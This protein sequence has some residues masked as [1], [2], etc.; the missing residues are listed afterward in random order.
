[1]EGGDGGGGI[2]CFLCGDY[3]YDVEFDLTRLMWAQ[4][5]SSDSRSL[6]RRP[7]SLRPSLFTWPLLAQPC[8]VRHATHGLRGFYN[9]GSTCFMSCILQALLHNPV[10][11][12]F[13]LRRS[14]SLAT[15]PKA[16]GSRKAA[17]LVWEGDTAGGGKEGGQV[18]ARTLE[19]PCAVHWRDQG[20][21]SNGERPGPTSSSFVTAPCL[22][23]ELQELFLLVFCREPTMPPPVLLARPDTVPASSAD[24]NHQHHPQA[25]REQ[26]KKSLVAAAATAAAVALTPPSEPLVPHRLMQAMWSL[27]SAEHLAGYE[28]QDAHEFL[29]ALLDALHND[30]ALPPSRPPTHTSPSSRH[31]PAIVHALRKEDV[32]WTCR[33]SPMNDKLNPKESFS[34]GDEREP[35]KKEGK[36]DARREKV[37]PAGLIHSA[38]RGTLRSDVVCASCQAVST[39]YEPFLDLSLPLE[40]M[41][42]PQSPAATRDAREESGAMKGH[43]DTRGEMGNGSSGRGEGGLRGN[44]GLSVAAVG[45]YP[46]PAAGTTPKSRAGRCDGGDGLRMGDHV[47]GGGGGLLRAGSAQG[48]KVDETGDVSKDKGL[49]N[50][51]ENQEPLTGCAEIPSASPSSSSPPSGTISSSHTPPAASPSSLP[52]SEG[53]DTSSTSLPR[54]VRRPSL[55]PLTPPPSVLDEL[56]LSH[57]LDAYTSL[58]T[59]S[60]PYKCASCGATSSSCSKQLTLHR[61][62]NVFIFHMKRFDAFSARKIEKFVRYPPKG[63]N[64]GPYMRAWRNAEMR[65]GGT[66]AKRK[67]ESLGNGNGGE[68]CEKRARGGD[69]SPQ[70]EWSHGRREGKNGGS[71]S[72]EIP[73]DLFAVVEH[74]GASLQQGHYKAFVQEGTEGEKEG[75]RE[76][77]RAPAWYVCNDTWVQAVTM[78]KVLNAQAYLLFY[79]RRGWNPKAG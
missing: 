77:G 70:T 30:L 25:V 41:A 7:P 8:L 26:Y 47:G 12:D 68:R 15:C 9:L 24:T 62:P 6:L 36:E 32:V 65:R 2:F 56:T 66:T 51:G 57:C 78:E 34:R 76:G 20:E 45:N 23:C 61:L 29:I 52:S 19:E 38:F 42:G 67:E 44:G 21:R 63:L 54:P 28:Q 13:F 60:C 72:P 55:R 53:L 18:G 5:R 3:V 73:Y 17:T 39:V 79:I 33:T 35:C 11:K 31:T 59:L 71:V 48:E 1:M 14:H 4:A 69:G 40:K 27:M 43:E 46:S 16:Q 22:A 64:M 74:M 75:G 58:E 49:E 50:P 37:I 10:L